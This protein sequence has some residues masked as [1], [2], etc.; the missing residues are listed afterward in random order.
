MRVLLLH[1]E[2]S[3]RSGPWSRERWDLVVDLG[4]STPFSRQR[5]EKEC[6]C[7]FLCADSFREGV[8]DA[9]RVRE[10]FA[11][12]RGRLIDDVGLDHWELISVAFVLQALVVLQLLRLRDQIPQGAEVWCTRTDWPVNLFALLLERPARTFDRGRP[13]AIAVAAHYVEVLRR[14][15]ASQIREILL[16]KYDSGYKWRSRFAATLVRS[17]QP[18]VLVPSAYKNVSRMAAAY[19]DLLP[20]QRFLMIATR[21]SARQ[22]VEPG[23]V[24][25]RD[26]AA[27]ARQSV[28][29]SE[30]RALQEHWSVL[31]KNLESS[32]V[33]RW[34][35]AAGV[36][37]PVPAWLDDNIR[38]RNAWSEVLDREPV[39][40]VLCGDDSNRFTRMP[41]LLAAKRNI[42]TAN[43][44][45]GALDGRYL[46]KE[47]PSDLYLAKSE[48]ERDYL[49]RVCG[50]SA[51][52]VVI[53]PPAAEHAR[54]SKRSLSEA[55]Y[56][57][58]FSEPYEASGLRC[59]EVYR[60][61][62]PSL[63][64]V[65]RENGRELVIKLH[66]FESRSERTRILKSVLPAEDARRVRVI[67]GSL[68]GE[69][70]EQ[71][72][73]GITVESTTV[74]DC[75]QNGVG[76]FL[77]RWMSLSPYEYAQQYL[78]FGVGEMLESAEQIADIPGRLT[79]SYRQASVHSQ[80]AASDP[81]TLRQWL[82]RR[83]REPAVVRSA[84]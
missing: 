51:D 54:P 72:W 78:R 17:H 10:I 55:R 57:V 73:F 8:A 59:E 80:A 32:H 1:P 52:R 27:Y 84:S 53:A 31:R 22:F 41:V 71:A 48:M 13:K 76:C 9:R 46:Y 56:A 83:F 66:P 43:F 39:C 6:G 61:L 5:W 2:D 68:S 65:A 28:S 16:D 49:L 67:E 63:W 81:E 14:F 33:L 69:L 26:L 25:V 37:D 29:L 70:M 15:P 20:Q 77:C 36:F 30:T 50:L 42:P 74:I 47:L 21:E 19:A 44:H 4:A 24:Q 18:V 58:L 3:P 45:H 60:E 82:A 40:G 62:L 64:R 75:L 38:S 34:M 12:G 11:V 35:F 23:N 79:E 7:P